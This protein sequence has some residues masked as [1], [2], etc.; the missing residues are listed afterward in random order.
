MRIDC[1]ALRCDGK[2]T[3]SAGNAIPT[4]LIRLLDHGGNIRVAD[5][6]S[7]ENDAT[8]IDR[9]KAM[10]VVRIGAGYD[11]WDGDRLVFRHRR[12]GLPLS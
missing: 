12:G 8:A 7:C 4:Y 5:W 2:L 10:D 11:V 3:F 9:A 1:M 6:I